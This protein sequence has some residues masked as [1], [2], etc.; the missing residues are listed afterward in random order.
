MAATGSNLRIK[1]PILHTEVCLLSLVLGLVPRIL[2][3]GYES[4]LGLF[5]V[6]LDILASILQILL[7]LLCVPIGIRR[8]DSGIPV[9][10][11]DAL[12]FFPIGLFGVWNVVIVEP[13]L[14]FVFG[15][16]L[17]S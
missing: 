3:L 16:A 4:I 9:L 14:E 6:F 11:D 8:R 12:Q 1:D 13:A 10:P 15:P 2:N 5:G 7:K 17:V